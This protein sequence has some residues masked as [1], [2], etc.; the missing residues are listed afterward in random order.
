MSL[1]ESESETSPDSSVVVDVVI[2]DVEQGGELMSPGTHGGVVVSAGGQLMSPPI[3]VTAKT[4]IKVKETNILFRLFMF[5][6]FLVGTEFC[7]F[8]KR[9]SRAPAG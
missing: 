2:D 5:F 8:S 9:L 7:E 3:A 6:S 4:D 1:M